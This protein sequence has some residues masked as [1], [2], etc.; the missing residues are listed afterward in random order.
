MTVPHARL[1]RT[2]LLA[3]FITG[4]SISLSSFGTFASVQGQ[5]SLRPQSLLVLITIALRT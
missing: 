3:L 2:S 1:Q 4:I 5:T